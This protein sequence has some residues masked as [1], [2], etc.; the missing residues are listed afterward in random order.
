MFDN[1]A[2]R[3]ESVFK[4][5]R[6]QGRLTEANMREALQQIRNALLEADVNIQ[7]TKKFIANVQEAALGQEVLA[8]IHPGQQ[9]VKIVHD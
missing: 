3:L 1:L 4:T 2:K 9:I 5:I 8:S 6:G 7:V